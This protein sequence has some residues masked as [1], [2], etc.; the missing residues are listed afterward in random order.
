MKN[1]D[2]FS[3][4]MA[5]FLGSL[6]VGKD[7]LT[8]VIL[9]MLAFVGEEAVQVIFRRNF[10]PGGLSGLRIVVCFILFELIAVIF[11]LLNLYA[12]GSSKIIGSPESFAWAGVFYFILGFIV[13]RNG[14]KGI[15]KARNSNR[16]YKFVGESAV[17]SFLK[18]DGWS[19]NKI[20]NLAEPILTLAVGIFLSF[21]NILWGIPIIYCA[22]SVW[23]CM[24]MDAIFLE[25][26]EPQTTNRR[27]DDRDSADFN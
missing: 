26:P 2:E 24:V 5:G 12:D 11:F 22:L 21:I 25:T 9:A 1:R 6:I 14:L 10:G 17:L 20:Q 27:S 4:R 15:A 16:P 13:L 23:A 3:E 18:K 19:E 8:W 7:K